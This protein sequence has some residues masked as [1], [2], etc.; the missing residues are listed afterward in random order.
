MQ[1]WKK[2]QRN[3]DQ[4]EGPPPGT[5]AS[6]KRKFNQLGHNCS[7]HAGA[8]AEGKGSAHHE[9]S[10]KCKSK[11]TKLP[12]KRILE[13]ILDVLQ[14]RDTHEIFAEPVDPNEVEDYYKIIKEPMD[15]GTMRAKLHE[16]M[17]QNL[18]QFEHD[19]FL[20]PQNAMHFNSSG[21]IY[22]R[23]ARAI[24]ELAKKVFHVL[25]TNPGNFEAEFPVTR[26]RSMRR[27]QNEA[28][29]D[30][31]NS[32]QVVPDGVTNV[33]S[34]N[35]GLAPSVPSTYRRSS[36]ERPS[37]STKGAS[38]IDSS[39]LL[40]KTLDNRNASYRESLMSFAKDL[41]PVAQMVANQKMQGNHSFLLSHTTKSPPTCLGFAAFATVQSQSNAGV[42]TSSEKL[43]SPVRGFGSVL[44]STSDKI[45]TNGAKGDETCKESAMSSRKVPLPRTEN[46]KK[47]TPILCYKRNVHKVTEE[48]A[49]KTQ[50]GSESRENSL[51]SHISTNGAPGDTKKLGRRSAKVEENKVLPVVLALEQSRSSLA[52]LKW[53]HK[54][55]SK[56]TSRIKQSQIK[57]AE[58]NV[59]EKVPD[60]TKNNSFRPEHEKKEAICDQ[61]K[62]VDSSSN[63]R[64]LEPMSQSSKLKLNKE[65]PVVPFLAKASSRFVFDM[66]FLQAQLNKMNPVGKNDMSQVA[67]DNMER[68]LY[69]QGS[70]NKMVREVNPSL[71]LQ[72]NSNSTLQT[73]PSCIYNIQ[74]SYCSLDTD[75][76]LQL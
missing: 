60:Q 63:R 57:I 75:L 33:S 73:M 61:N 10:S 30:T 74:S 7:K 62:N 59:T 42:L 52:E 19:A 51:A 23:Q 24:H 13:L 36:K 50:N 70:Y 21:T 29:R 28:A 68:S 6:I 44:K 41:G 35:I 3:K 15:F 58:F 43:P 66:P 65:I 71:C 72:E 22:F 8:V 27:L 12:E 16:G 20:I 34:K 40:G 54:K 17:Y 55:G 37:L 32:K 69:G 64:F 45:V 48:A 5:R 76:A 67:R 18:Q 47:N 2:G 46:T 4:S 11:P 56:S 49:K 31:R 26:R 9:N 38:L 1:R 53:R 25:K 39:F 14:R